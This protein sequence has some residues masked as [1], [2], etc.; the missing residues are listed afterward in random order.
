MIDRILDALHR[1][2]HG[3]PVHWVRCCYDGLGWRTHCARC[4]HPATHTGV[5]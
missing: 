1:R 5:L 4:G 3:H 2:R